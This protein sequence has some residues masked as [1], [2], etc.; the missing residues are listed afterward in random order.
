MSKARASLRAKANA[1]KKI[2]KRAANAAKPEQPA[3]PG[4]FD[5]GTQNIK[6]PH[7]NANANAFAGAKRGSARSK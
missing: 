6:S 2:K 5:P 7:T 3:R 4:H 1:L